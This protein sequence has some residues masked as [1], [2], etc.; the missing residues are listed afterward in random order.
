MPLFISPIN[1]LIIKSGDTGK[2]KWNEKTPRLSQVVTLIFRLTNQT[3]SL[4]HEAFKKNCLSR[5]KPHGSPKWMKTFFFS[6]FD[7]NHSVFFSSKKLIKNTRSNKYF[8]RPAVK[9]GKSHVFGVLVLS[10]YRNLFA[11]SR[12]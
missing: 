8:R 5:Y 9:W 3:E 7:V 12:K 4:T 1:S 10:E 2:G 6:W 11:G